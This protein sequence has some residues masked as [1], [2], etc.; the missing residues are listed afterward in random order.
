VVHVN[1]VV[2]SKLT[3]TPDGPDI[4][5]VARSLQ[6]QV[7][8]DFGPAWGVD[9]T[10]SFPSDRY[11]S[12]RCWRLLLVDADSKQENMTVEA[13]TGIVHVDELPEGSRSWSIEASHVL[14]ELLADPF[15]SLAA[16]SGPMPGSSIYAMEVCDPCAGSTYVIHDVEVANFVLPSWFTRAPTTSIGRAAAPAG[17][18]DDF[19]QRR[20][21]P[22]GVDYLGLLEAP[23]QLLQG[24]GSTGVLAADPGDATRL[25][26]QR[27]LASG[28]V[29]D[30]GDKTRLSRRHTHVDN[31]AMYNG[32]TLS[33]WLTGG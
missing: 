9:A 23:F 20:V 29:A 6:E 4:D 24:G 31:W 12:H 15:S 8:G 16:C 2:L 32:W 3:R 5:T 13:P 11:Y 1:V 26:W 22:P 28:Q 33:G 25:S 10:V 7:R 17:A 30:I 19:S 21:P 14:L 27:R 18:E